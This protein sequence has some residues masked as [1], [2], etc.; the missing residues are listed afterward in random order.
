[1]GHIFPAIGSYETG[2]LWRFF[3]GVSSAVSS[4]MAQG[5]TPNEENLT[6]LLCELLDANT[7]SLHTLSYPLSQAKTDLEATD[8]GITLDVE[9]QTHE[10]TKYV[11][12][13]F[14]GAD[15][16]IVLAV[17]HPILGWSRRGV[18][19]QAKRL[20]SSGSKREYRLF[21]EYSSFDKKQAEFLGVLANRFD[22]WNSVFY[23]WYNPPSTAFTEPE[24]KILR[25]YETNGFFPFRYLHR[26][27][28]FFDEM[29][30]MGFPWLLGVGNP[31]SASASDEA[32]A[33]EWRLTQPALRVSSLDTARSVGEHGVPQLKTLYDTML[34]RRSLPIFSPLAD[35]FILA[36]IS[37]SYGS[38]NS[39]WLR[40]VEGQ[41]IPL[42][43]AK[44]PKD[45][46][47]FD[48][49][50]IL[51]TPRHTLRIT[52]RSTLPSL[53]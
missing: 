40:L 16:G 35:F 18:L 50:N 9:F 48:E 30:E 27:H 15:L 26:M 23:L 51:P 7:T 25:A 49:L 12:S 6:F 4:R 47:E 42:P 11:E 53:G 24:A 33:K 2:I 43:S 29:M 46:G 41:K 10:H 1:M 8:S 28:P 37:S 5:S 22:V 21:S 19:L 38:G 36:L 44:S 14:S 52:I 17:N 39:D 34:T 13:K 20:F 32:K 3:D 45:V 31:G